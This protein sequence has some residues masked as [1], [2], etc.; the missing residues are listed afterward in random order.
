MSH[1]SAIVLSSAVVV[2]VTS[3]C[4]GASLTGDGGPPAGTPEASTGETHSPA[5]TDGAP[6][7]SSPGSPDSG[8]C[9]QVADPTQCSSCLALSKVCEVCSNGETKCAHY[10][11]RDGSCAV[12]TCSDSPSPGDAGAAGDVDSAGDGGTR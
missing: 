2:F 12:E 6:A 10:V 9:T 11:V 7:D 4:G 8:G 1:E 3:A 5:A